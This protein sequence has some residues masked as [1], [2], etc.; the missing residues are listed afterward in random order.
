MGFV[1]WKAP[2]SFWA[3]RQVQPTSSPTWLLYEQTFFCH[4][5]KLILGLQVFEQIPLLFRTEYMHKFTV[6][7]SGH[8]HDHVP[9]CEI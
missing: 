9:H 4:P 3:T 7:G 5:A 8:C 6:G 1:A 2:F